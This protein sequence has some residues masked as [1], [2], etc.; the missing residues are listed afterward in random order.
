MDR[1][2]HHLPAAVA[3]VVL[4]FFCPWRI[5]PARRLEW[6][7]YSP[8]DQALT[9]RP[10]LNKTKREVQ[11]PVDPE[12][13]PELMA[14]IE[15][16]QARRRP[17]CPFIFHGKLCRTVRFDENGNR[18]AQPTSHAVRRGDGYRTRPLSA[19]RPAL[20]LK[21]ICPGSRRRHGAIRRAPRLQAI[22]PLLRR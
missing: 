19:N 18:R 5:G 9:L 16:Q 11:I 8:I 6:R 3:D 2:W 20:P 14:I 12:H 4:F 22:R 21:S 15:R 7:D 10:E 13:T 1:L 17:D